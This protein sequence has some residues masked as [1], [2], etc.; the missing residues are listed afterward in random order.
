MS[1]LMARV[2]SVVELVS[3]GGGNSRD[4]DSGR[5]D[6]HSSGLHSSRR[7]SLMMFPSIPSHQVGKHGKW[8]S[9]HKNLRAWTTHCHYR[10]YKC[11]KGE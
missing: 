7:P 5:S 3:G 9:K 10:T 6:D 8:M 2:V 11:L 4:S 1:G